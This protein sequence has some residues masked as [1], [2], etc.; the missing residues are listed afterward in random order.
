MYKANRFLMG[1]HLHR[2]LQN[3]FLNSCSTIGT[4]Q[5]LH[6]HTSHPVLFAPNLHAIV[7]Q[8]IIFPSRR[9]HDCQCRVQKTSVSCC[10]MKTLNM[11]M[12]IKRTNRYVCD[13]GEYLDL[14]RKKKVDLLGLCF[15]RNYGRISSEVLL[16]LSR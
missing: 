1:E 5:E 4:S 8:N 10:E 12:P 9:L 3:H 15:S 2:R 13:S 6:P 7:F 11:V 16:H 14:R